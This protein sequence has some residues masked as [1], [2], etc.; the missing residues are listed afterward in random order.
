MPV[1]WCYDVEDGQKYCNPGFPIGCL[2]AGD[3]RAK[4]ACVI[5]VSLGFLTLKG[6]NNFNILSDPYESAINHYTVSKGVKLLFSKQAWNPATSSLS[7]FLPVSHFI[8][9][10]V[11]Q[12]Y[13]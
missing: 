10:T 9:S 7:C 12:I 4:D 3:G 5:N 2:V 11:I 8:H 6:F 1:T 13:Q